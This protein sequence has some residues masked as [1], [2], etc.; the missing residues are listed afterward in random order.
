MTMISMINITN[1]ADIDECLV[2]SPNGFCQQVCVNTL[3]SYHCDCMEGYQ[4]FRT[5]LC[6]GDIA[7]VYTSVKI[8]S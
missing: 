6:L 4:L 8:I 2:I 1:T 7:L 3:G 5:S